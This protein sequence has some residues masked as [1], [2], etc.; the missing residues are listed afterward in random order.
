MRSRADYAGGVSDEPG[1][2]LRTSA[3]V[4]AA[5]AIPVPVLAGVLTLAVLHQLNPRGASL[6]AFPYGVEV[7]IAMAVA[8]LGMIAAITTVFALLAR[9]DR[10]ALRYPALVIQL[11]KAQ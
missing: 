3:F 4:L 2:G 5:S 1:A 10:A 6:T 7:T 8:A 11:Q 9:R